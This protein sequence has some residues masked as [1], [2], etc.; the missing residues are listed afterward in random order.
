ML[1]WLLNF[2]TGLPAWTMFMLTT[3]GVILFI[4]A[5]ASALKLSRS[6]SKKDGQWRL[7]TKWLAFKTFVFVVFL[8]AF[9]VAFGPGIPPQELPSDIGI[10]E[11][12]DKAPDMKTQTEIDEEAAAKVD[13]F[14]KKQDE[15][16]KAEQK[17]AD[18]YLKEIRKKHQNQ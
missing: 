12:V 8:F 4:W 17:E 11:Y 3:S 15:G 14:L 2:G 18:A 5:V 10:M 9:G 6:L 1:D 13:P 16:F 7:H